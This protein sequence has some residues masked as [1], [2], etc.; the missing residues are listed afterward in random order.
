MKKT[1]VATTLLAGI[2]SAP[3]ALAF[4]EVPIGEP[5]NMNGMEIAA[6]YLQPVDMEPRGMGLSAKQSDI[7]LE[8]DIHADNG[9]KNGFGEGEWIP[10]LTIAYKLTNLDTGATQEGNFMP[11]VA[12][13]GPHY[14]ANIKMMGPGN[15]KVT[16]HIDPPPK[17]GMHRHTDKDTGVA[18]FWKPFDVSYEFKYVGLN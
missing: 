6:V 1:L 14:G 16:Y 12:S 10:Y 17:A 7:H 15:Y 8:A 5:I 3:A 9:N 18:R 2:L 11:M 4:K 13:D